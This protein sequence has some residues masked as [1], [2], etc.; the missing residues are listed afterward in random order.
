MPGLQRI[1]LRRMTGEAPNILTDPVYSVDFSLPE[2]SYSFNLTMN[3][4]GTFK[5]YTIAY[6]VAGNV[7]S[8]SEIVIV[9][10]ESSSE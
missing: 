3:D 4:T 10:V 2:G 9:K 8:V 1:E 6:D 7:S 5:F